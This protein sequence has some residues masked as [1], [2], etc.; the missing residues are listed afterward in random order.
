[1]DYPW[2]K[3]AGKLLQSATLLF[4][5]FDG[6]SVRAEE[7][8]ALRIMAAGSL[9]PAMTELLVAFNSISGR[10]A[11]PSFG[12]SGLLRKQIEGGQ[13]VDLFASA[14]M[15][16]PRM[17][18]HAR[19]GLGAVLFARNKLCMLVRDGIGVNQDNLLEGLLQP[20]VRLATSTPSSDPSGDYTW[21]MFARAE[22]IR[23]GAQAL[24]Q[25]KAMQLVGGPDSRPLV[26][27]HN[28]VAGVFMADRADAM[29]VYCSGTSALV[30]EVPGL[31][32]V[33]L[34]PSLA[35]ASA[36]G[37]IVLSD[38]PDAARLAVFI[39][40][41]AGQDILVRHGFEPATKAAD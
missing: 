1:M 40:S 38:D 36:A 13:T 26:P 24:L 4:L 30:K 39:L 10:T 37:L 3:I 23:P 16:Q 33:S 11:G 19:K 32:S 34:P 6:G 8:A 22:A 41:E 25:A 12:A 18:A 7:R 35:V 2:L 9:K 31:V 20:S 21:A 29:P 17:L 15:N 14:D 27:G 5:V 28:A